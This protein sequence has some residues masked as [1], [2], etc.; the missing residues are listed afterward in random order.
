VTVRTF[1]RLRWKLPLLFALATLVFA[2]IVALAVAL[3]LRG[4]FLDRLQ[5]DM[6]Q[7]VHQYAAV[8]EG[9]NPAADDLQPLTVAVGGAANARFTVID[10]Q[11]KVLAD[12]LVDPSTLENHRSRPEVAQALAGHEGR[13]RRLSATLSQE[14]VYV[15]IPLPASNATWSQGVLRVAQPASR[16]DA[17]VAASWRIPLIV[18][19]VLLLPMLAVAYLTT[20]T[21]V[22]PIERLRQMTAQVAAGDL[23]HRT[24]VRR[25]DEL[26]ELAE[27]L[28]TM[29]T[30][31]ELRDGEL[32]AELERS[33]QVLTAMNEGV[34]LVEGDGRLLRSNP[35][36]GKILGVDLERME[37][38][39]M[40][41]AARSF[42]AQALAEKARS[43]GQPLTEVLDLPSGRSLTVEVVPLRGPASSSPGPTLFVVRD[44]TVRRATERMRRD[45]ATNVSHELKTPLAG[46]SLLA[47]TLAGIVRDDP[48]QAEKFVAQL[49]AEIGRLTELTNDLLTLSRLEEPENPSQ[50]RFESVDFGR[51][52]QEVA[53]EVRPLAVA[54]SHEL[55]VDA[56]AGIEVLGD[57]VALRTLVRNLLENAIRYTERGGAVQ[58]EVGAEEGSDGSGW[59]VLKVIDN[60]VGIP[61]A[62]QQRIFERFY[63]VDKARSR[64]TGGTGLGLSIVRHVAQRHG[65]RV[66]VQSTLGVGSTFTVRLPRE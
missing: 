41:L 19:A 54:K 22:R 17:L 44:E 6:S 35:A 3:L 39:A 47:Q 24:S 50:A 33:S 57:E 36:A 37:G 32:G 56:P 52:A 62:D 27:S 51:L 31:L 4:V 49:L 28:N 1:R 66:E 18:W 20:H 40:V 38:K 25:S 61:L 63:R 10:H 13:A 30:Q 34:L 16:V 46:L 53:Q 21:L 42:P 7:Q 58:V 64:E 15:A 5:D 29:A 60:G 11:G 2:G 8:L 12:S 55:E 48:E 23:S 43:A 26:G 59:A 45:F 65:G 9:T 14:E